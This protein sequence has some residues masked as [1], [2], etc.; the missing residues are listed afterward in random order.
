MK[1][2]NNI[3]LTVFYKE[4]EDFEKIRQKLIE[5]IPFNLEEEKILLREE[6]ATGFNERKIK[7]HKIELTKEKH[8][9][10]FFANLRQKL[11]SLDKKIILSQIETRI[12]QELNFFIRLDK[13]KL[14]QDIYEIT[15]SG[16][17]YHIKISLSAFPK[18]REKAVE[19]AKKLLNE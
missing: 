6:T 15:D 18:K 8:T 7:I 2:F 4:D 3:I 13:Q 11:S 9:N 17:C 10:K 12:D 1:N 19:L 16:D 5:L 14:L